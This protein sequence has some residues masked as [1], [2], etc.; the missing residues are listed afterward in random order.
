MDKFNFL[1][2]NFIWSKDI[3]SWG[4]NIFLAHSWIHLWNN[5][6]FKIWSLR[7]GG[8]I[9]K[10]S[11]IIHF[12]CFNNTDLFQNA[13][14][15]IKCQP[16]KYVT[17]LTSNLTSKISYNN[18]A[19]YTL[20]VQTVNSTLKLVWQKKKKKL[21]TEKYPIWEHTFWYS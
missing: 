8:Q 14:W 5:I 13:L 16:S 19:P 2:V 17:S 3:K 10:L 20:Y 7:V 6:H 11:N 21:P 18:N 15:D 4:D 9:W 12:W 1:F